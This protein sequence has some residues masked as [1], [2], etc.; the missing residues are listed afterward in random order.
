MELKVRTAVR[1]DLPQ[2]LALYPHLNPDDDIPSP[3]MAASRFDAL[4]KFDGSAIFIGLVEDIVVCSCTLVIIPNLTR[5]GAPY[6][7]IENVVTHASYRGRGFGKLI[8]RAAVDA[9]WQADCYK[10]MLLTGS[11]KPSTLA[12]YGSAGF[13][14]NKTG[15]QVRRIPVRSD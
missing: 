7:L 2:L 12:F 9:A 3:E 6:A 13:E 8:L 1:S 5:G 11:T 10:A 4:Q 15:F 14:Q